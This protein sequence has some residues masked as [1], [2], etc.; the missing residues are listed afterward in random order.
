[1]LGGTFDP[2]H[3]GHLLLAETAREELGLE[4]VL[5]IPAG[6]QWRKEEADREI[7]PARHRLE[8]VRLALDGNP[9][10]EA[11]VIEIERE[12]PSYSVETLEQLRGEMPDATLWFIAGADAIADMPNWYQTGRIFELAKVCAAGRPGARE[13]AGPL[14]DRVVW[15]DMPEM[16]ISST[17]IRERVRAGKSV[18]YMVPDAVLRYIEDNNLYED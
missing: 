4:R 9:A 14:A 2:V 6:H 11:S 5:F 17:S 15:L 13:K 8:M 18:R 3:I 7:S 1:M 12:G 10:F 16:E